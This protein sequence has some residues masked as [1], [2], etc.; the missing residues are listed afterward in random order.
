MLSHGAFANIFLMLTT[1]QLKKHN[2]SIK[3]TE[4]IKE[5]YNC[6]RKTM[7]ESELRK[8]LG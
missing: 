7:K 2:I 6:V 8:L 5:E 1:Y 4:L 3:K